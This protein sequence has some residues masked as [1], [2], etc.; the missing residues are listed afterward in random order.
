MWDIAGS[1]TAAQAASPILSLAQSALPGRQPGLSPAG[2]LPLSHL[3]LAFL[4]C[5]TCLHHPLMTSSCAGKVTCHFF[6]KSM[7]SDLRVSVVV[8]LSEQLL[9]LDF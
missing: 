8:D 2:Y 5:S 6:E 3:C 4:H 1:H 9:H 7:E